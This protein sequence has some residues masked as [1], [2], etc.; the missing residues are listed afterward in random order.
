MGEGKSLC[1]RRFS[2]PCAAVIEHNPGAVNAKWTGQVEDPKMYPSCQDAVC[3]DGEAIEFEWQILPGFATLTILQEIPMDLERTNKEPQNFKDRIILMFLFR[4]LTVRTTLHEHHTMAQK[5]SMLISSGKRMMRI[6]CRTLR[7]SRNTQRCFYQDTR[8]SVSGF[9]KRNGTV[10][11][12]MDNGTV[13]PTSW[14][15]TSMKLVILSSQPLVLW[16]AECWNRV[17]VNV[18]ITSMVISWTQN[19]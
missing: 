16:V 5:K 13:Q 6:A 4:T 15:S 9:W 17:K 11:H 7:V 1:L 3:L 14:C 18:P 12:M 2:S 19:Y 10:A 8:L